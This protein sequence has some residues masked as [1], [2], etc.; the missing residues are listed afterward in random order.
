MALTYA[1]ATH[2]GLVRQRNEDTYL[3]DGEL[4]LFAVIDGIGG[5]AGGDV[6]S[7]RVADAVVG[8]I[9]DT[10][11]DP[12]KTWPVALEPGLSLN[13]NR[14]QAAIRMASRSVASMARQHAELSGSGATICAALF[15]AGRL[16][17]SNVGD[18]RAYLIRRGELRQITRD[19]SVVAEQLTTGLID[20]DQARH[21]P[22]RHVITRAVA[23]DEQVHAD[24]WELDVEDHDR[25]VLC[26][27]GVHAHIDP[28]ELAPLL[29]DLTQLPAQVCD[30]AIAL[31]NAAGGADNATIVVIDVHDDAES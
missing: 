23:G 10:A 22:L 21:H 17:L 16:A 11:A 4:G 29:L 31:A 25:L 3:A 12:D 24:T 15:A 1:G 14:L 9:R 20:S 13:A 30:Q 27:D 2:V 19:H 18:C 6:A 28:G 8:F 5:H 26:S 7:R